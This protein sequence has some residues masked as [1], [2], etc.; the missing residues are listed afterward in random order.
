MVKSYSQSS[1]YWFGCGGKGGGDSGEGAQR[2]S[3]TKFKGTLSLTLFD[4]FSKTAPK[5]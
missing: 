2:G 5:L 4:F 1:I 3:L